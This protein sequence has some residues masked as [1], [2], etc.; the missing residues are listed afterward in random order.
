MNQKNGGHEKQVLDSVRTQHKSG[1][2][3]S[4]SVATDDRPS[5]SRVHDGTGGE[6][7]TPSDEMVEFHEESTSSGNQQGRRAGNSSDQ[8][9][10][11]VITKRRSK[12][13]TDTDSERYESD[14]EESEDYETVSER[15]DLESSSES[16]GYSSTEG[17]EIEIEDPPSNMKSR[18][19]IPP[20][21]KG[22][23]ISELSSSDDKSID[24]PEIMD[25][26]AP[27]TEAEEAQYLKKKLEFI[28]GFR[29][30]KTKRFD[31]QDGIEKAYESIDPLKRTGKLNRYLTNVANQIC[32]EKRQDIEIQGG[33][34][35]RVP[36]ES[37]RPRK[38]DEIISSKSSFNAKPVMIPIG[39]N[40]ALAD[41]ADFDPRDFFEHKPASR[42]ELNLI[43]NFSQGAIKL[44]MLNR[45]NHLRSVADMENLLW[46]F[47]NSTLADEIGAVQL[48]EQIRNR[49]D[50]TALNL[51][52]CRE[53]VNM[54][55]LGQFF[56]ACIG[57]FAGFSEE[58]PD[59][60]STKQVIVAMTQ[61]SS[62]AHRFRTDSQ[63]PK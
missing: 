18:G 11:A 61:N 2:S 47:P 55:S 46:K 15:T 27:V 28:N 44:V 5:R 8:R 60:K 13:P 6:L 56:E 33:N 24:V 35:N 57:N 12:V 21:W 7:L 29:F 16:S 19:P 58:E 17:E 51:N 1:Q 43:E 39:L 54:E 36:E 53:F 45:L 49:A 22:K 41:P 3:N 31:F 4:H 37:L 42:Q 34:C 59:R 38:Y 14:E 20:R 30:K 48:A 63:R 52:E 25:I 9:S 26:F 40:H 62:T 50:H 32:H 10:L 23:T